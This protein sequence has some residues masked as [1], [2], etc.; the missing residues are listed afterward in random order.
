MQSYVE[1]I[2]QIP[3][4]EEVEWKAGADGMVLSD[5]QMD[6]ILVRTV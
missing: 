2:I 3:A 4:D 6:A 5:I 1:R